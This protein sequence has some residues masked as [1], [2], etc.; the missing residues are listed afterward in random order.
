MSHFKLVVV[1]TSVSASEG[2]NERRFSKMPA[3]TAQT[4]H[5]AL[6]GDIERTQRRTKCLEDSGPVGLLLLV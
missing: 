3:M 5:R 1:V 2:S 4:R 6:S